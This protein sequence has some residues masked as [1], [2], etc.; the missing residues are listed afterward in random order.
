MQLVEILTLTLR[1]PIY[2]T[3]TIDWHGITRGL[4]GG[5]YGVQHHFNN[6]SQLYRG[7]QVYW[8][9]KPEK[10]SALSQVTDKLYHTMQYRVHLAFAGFP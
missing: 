7:G 5:D 9:R 8:W 6:I 2:S 3:H 4:G 1:T 10:T